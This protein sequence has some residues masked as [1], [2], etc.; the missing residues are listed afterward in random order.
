MNLKKFATAC[1]LSFAV[2]DSALAFEFVVC[3]AYDF[4]ELKTFS[5]AELQSKYNEYESI[6][7]RIGTMTPIT[8]REVRE[9]FNDQQKCSG[10]MERFKR[11]I[12]ARA[13]TDS[14]VKPGSKKKAGA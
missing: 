5:T 1:L 3:R 6:Y 13:K 9:D 8:P 4:E 12:D 14:K 10:E 7:K 2:S 11:I